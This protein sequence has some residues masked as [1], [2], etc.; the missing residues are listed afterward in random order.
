MKTFQDIT[1]SLRKSFIIGAL[2]LGS[3]ALGIPQPATV[4]AGDACK[5]VK[6]KFTNERNTRIKVTKVDY[7]N[8]ANNKIQ[9][10]Q[11]TLECPSGS[12]CTS[13]GQDLRDSEGESLTN[14]VFYFNDQEKD[15]DWSK[16]DVKTQPKVPVNQICGAD[17][18]YSG[19]PV[20]TINP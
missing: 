1:H 16:V 14:F 17:R 6:F 10:E 2:V 7:L 4:H 9:T 12:T 11:F 13:S 18:I 19:N 5:N 8:K 3:T 15:G 20:W